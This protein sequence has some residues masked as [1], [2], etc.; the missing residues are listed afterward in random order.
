[1]KTPALVALLAVSAAVLVALGLWIVSRIRRNS[2]DR[3]RRRRLAVNARG[4]L[5]DATITDIADNTIFYSYTVS[6]VVYEGSQDISQL[7]DF[8]YGDTERVIGP[9][10]MKYSPRNPAN[11]IILCEEWSGLRDNMKPRSPAE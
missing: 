7:R 10:T 6:G 1:M 4:R 9:V 8:I 11:S 3:E 5:G 2:S